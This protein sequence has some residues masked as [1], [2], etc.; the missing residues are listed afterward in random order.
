M[1][2]RDNG[3]VGALLDEY[4]KA[5]KELSALLSTVTEA[6]YNT[7]VDPITSDEDCRSIHTIMNHVMNSGYY[8][9]QAIRNDNGEDVIGSVAYDCTTVPKALKELEGMLA[10]NEQLFLDYPNLQLETNQEELK[11]LTR[12]G[13]RYDVDQMME[14]AIVHIL[15]HRR[16]IERFLIKLRVSGG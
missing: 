9:A 8:Y 13:Q 7:V 15:R 5:L 6:E 2:Y 11:I 4:E 3:A 1:V 16:Q 14:H 12:W 10:Y